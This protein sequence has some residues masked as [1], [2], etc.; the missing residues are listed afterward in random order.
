LVHGRHHRAAWGLGYWRLAGTFLDVAAGADA[1]RAA[2]PG[3][4]L[5]PGRTLA[6]GFSAGGHLAL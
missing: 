4:R 1:L 2:A 3:H 5:D 6:L